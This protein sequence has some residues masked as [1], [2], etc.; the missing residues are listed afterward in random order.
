MNF[1]DKPWIQKLLF[2]LLFDEAIGEVV[3]LK[4]K[5]RGRRFLTLASALPFRSGTSL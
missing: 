5:M 2:K 4:D 1:L 3:S